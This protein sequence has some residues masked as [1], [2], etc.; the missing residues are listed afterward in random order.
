VNR[1]STGTPLPESFWRSLRHLNRFRYFLALFFVLGPLY[2]GLTVLGQLAPR[3]FLAIGLG[4]AALAWLFGRSLDRQRPS[5]EQQVARQVLLDALFITYLMH[6]SGGNA[7][8]LGL[9]LI[10]P[11]AAAGMHP[12]ARMTLFL[13]AFASLLILVE[14]VLHTLGL[15]AEGGFLR[16]GLLSTGLF[17]VAMFS[18]YLA[19][20]TLSASK[21]AGEKSAEAEELARINARVIEDLPHGVLVIDREGKVIQHN[22]RAEDLLQ[23]R[24]FSLA[25]LNHCAPQLAASWTEWR[26][27]GQVSELP[28]A[29][30]GGAR[31]LRARFSEL[32]PTRSE[33]AVIILEDMTEL[34]RTAQN[35]KLA[36][37][38]RLTANLAHEIRNPLSAIHQAA[39]LLR[40]DS[41]ADAV[42][43]RLTGIIDSNSKRLNTLVEDVLALSRRDRLDTEA[44]PVEEFLHGFVTEFQHAEDIPQGTFVVQ[45]GAQ[46]RVC[47]DRL[48]LNQ[49]LWNL[50]RNAWRYCTRA[51]RSVQLRGVAG[52]NQVYIEVYNDGAP[53]TAEM[54][55]RLFEPFFTTDRRGTG[56]GLN[57]AR[58]LAE[59]N[60]GGL[61][62]V[63]QADGALFRLTCPNPPCERP[64]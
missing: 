9:L 60:G 26:R 37:L 7:S 61:G 32:E 58:E 33:G 34:E 35:M 19:G 24:I 21:L 48:H 59:A 10:V 8:G 36:A 44:I 41:Q 47:F 25:N 62:Y 55:A 11:L 23:C 45:A 5:F 6:L 31:R 54:Q 1:L 57:I 15:G 18:H 56:L 27:S 40:E 38:G 16:A 52:D 64:R 17:G 22:A 2:P 4:Y 42:T 28:F 30:G 46:L 49:I 43:Q 12:Q 51:P 20:S 53:I 29:M 13:A 39:S 14:Q 63:D 3:Q 50:S